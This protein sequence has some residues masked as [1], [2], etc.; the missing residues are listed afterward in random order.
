MLSEGI[1]FFLILLCLWTFYILF[2]WQDNKLW[3]MRYKFSPYNFPF[4]YRGKI[5]WYS[6]SCAVASFVFAQDKDKVWHILANKRGKGAAD[7]K[8]CWNCPC[9]F[10]DFGETCAQA[11]RRETF[12]E[13][14]VMIPPQRF[15]FLEIQDDPVDSNNQNV[16]MRFFVNLDD[17][18]TEYYT[19]R[20]T[21]KGEKNEVEEVLWMPV[22]DI[23]KYQWAFNHGEIIKSIYE[24]KILQESK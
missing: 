10:L 14:G 2:K 4:R 9:G 12:E 20:I 11:A 23:D 6:R 17:I 1:I 8:G 24:R 13:T 22:A 21:N 7:F 18:K 15:Q 3:W 5:L 19:P 16:T